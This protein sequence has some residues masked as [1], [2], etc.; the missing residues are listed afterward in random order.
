MSLRRHAFLFVAA[1]AAVA[2][3]M[4]AAAPPPPIRPPTGS[5]ANAAAGAAPSREPYTTRCELAA[6]R[7]KVHGLGSKQAY[8]GQQC[9]KLWQER[10]NNRLFDLYIEARQ[11]GPGLRTHV[12]AADAL[13]RR[14]RRNDG[15]RTLAPY[16]RP[17][18]LQTT[19]ILLHREKALYIEPVNL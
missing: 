11:K 3:A 12:R 16:D 1:C 4:P 19:G 5:A 10:L 18:L 6:L 13:Q 14:L 8:W 7:H 9:D 2:G 17:L 15:R